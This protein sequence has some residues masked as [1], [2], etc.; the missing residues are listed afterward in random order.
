MPDMAVLARTAGAPDNLPPIAKSIS[1]SL[2]PK[3]FPEIRRSSCSTT[4]MC[5]E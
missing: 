1:E 4:T 5:R 3:I 2:D